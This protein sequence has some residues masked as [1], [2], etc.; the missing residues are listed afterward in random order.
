MENKIIKKEIKIAPIKDGTVIDHVPNGLCFKIIEIMEIN[1]V[2]N[3]VSVG[4]NLDSEKIGKKAIIKISGKFL[5]EEE[6]AKISIIAPNVTMSIIR[7]YNVEK[8]TKLRLPDEI[9]GIIKCNNPN[10]VTNREN[11]ETKFY[12]VD[13]DSVKIK[14]NYCEREIE[15]CDIKLS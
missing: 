1:P 5:S 4:T 15:K 7:D 14:C 13:T 10:C 8:K 11:V 9:R 6:L 3:A 2:E 12:V